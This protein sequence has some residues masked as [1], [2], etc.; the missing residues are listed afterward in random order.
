MILYFGY[1]SNLRRASLRVKG[2]ELSRTEPAL[3]EGWR[4]IFNIA[5]PFPM[6]GYVANIVPAADG[7][8]HGALCAFE[9]EYLESL[10][11]YEGLG[12]YY[13]RRELEV[14]TYGGDTK[15]AFVYVGSP[16]MSGSEGKPSVRYRNI[17]VKGG[18]DVGLA[19]EYLDWLANVP[20]H[21][22][23]DYPPF[24][25]PKEPAK[26]FTLAQL[27]DQPLHTVLA[28][29]VFDMSGAGSGHM[30][31]RSLSDGQDVTLFFLRLMDS[32]VGTETDEDIA[33]DRLND[34]QR[35]YLNDYLHEFSRVYKCVGRLA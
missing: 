7:L 31:L 2:V 18:H 12:E 30:L 35:R 14:R 19:D 22:A 26:I 15:T 3:L 4:L 34:Q 10:D 27:A 21:P 24:V 1:G 32:S 9:D 28:G 23:P 5:H 6:E 29:H 8:V 13:E 25:P 16:A 17:L 11:R 20:V 33:S